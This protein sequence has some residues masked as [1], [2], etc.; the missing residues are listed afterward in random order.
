MKITTWF[1]RSQAILGIYEFLISDEYNQSY[2][3][4]I[5]WLFQALL[6]QGMAVD[7]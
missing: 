4:T 5:S 7:F 2:I 1:T 3:N 6:W